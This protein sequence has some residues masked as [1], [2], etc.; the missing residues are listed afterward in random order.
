MQGKEITGIQQI[1]IGVNNLFDAWKWYKN[2]FGMDVRV[3]EDEATAE[4]IL[5]HTG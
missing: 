5:Q 2:H 3:F 4:L 1:G